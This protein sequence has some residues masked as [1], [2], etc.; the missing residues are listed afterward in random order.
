MDLR[1]IL[2]S[3]LPGDFCKSGPLLMGACREFLDLSPLGSVFPFAHG[4]K[5]LV[6]ALPCP[7]PMQDLE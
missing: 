1:K 2:G 4:L 6:S 5:P 7:A 3:S